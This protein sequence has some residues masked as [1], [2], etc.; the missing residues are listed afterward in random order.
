MQRNAKYF[1]KLVS[2]T[3]FKKASLKGFPE[4]HWRFKRLGLGWGNEEEQEECAVQTGMGAEIQPGGAIV[5]GRRNKCLILL[6]QRIEKS[7]RRS[8]NF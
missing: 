6:C 4:K 2:E 5:K 1:Q 3:D 7:M 8:E